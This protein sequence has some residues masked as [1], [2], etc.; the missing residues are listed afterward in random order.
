MDALASKALRAIRGCVS[1]GRY[2]VLAHFAH[3]MDLRGVFWA[4]IQAVIDSA[5]SVEDDGPDRFGRPKWRVRGRT[6]DRMDLGI[7]CVLDRDERGPVAVFITAY[8]D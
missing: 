1:D 7:V 5:E 6:T 4:D 3:R 8:W 2:R